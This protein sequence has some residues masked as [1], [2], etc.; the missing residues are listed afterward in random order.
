MKFALILVLW[1]S[2]LAAGSAYGAAKYVDPACANG[3][4]TYNAL[5]PAGTR[6]SGSGGNTTVYSSL[7]NAVGNLAA[8]DFLYIR[9]GTYPS[10]NLTNTFMPSG[11]GS[12]GSW[13]RLNPGAAFTNPITIQAYPGDV[14]NLQKDSDNSALNVTSSLNSDLSFVVFKDLI[15][16]G[17]LG[18]N[19]TIHHI[20]F[21]NITVNGNSASNCVGVNDP[22]TGFLWFTGGRYHGCGHYGFYIAA[23]DHIV[24]NLQIDNTGS[25]NDGLKLAI[26]NYESSCIVCP[27][28]NTYRNLTVIN[29]GAVL[30]WKGADNWLYNSIVRDNVDQG[31][32]AGVSVASGASGT[33]I[34]GNTLV[35]NTYGIILGEIGSLPT[36]TEFINNIVPVG[37]A[38]S[39]INN[40]TAIRLDNGATLAQNHNNLNTDPKFVDAPNGDY[41]PCIAA[42]DPHPTCTGASDAIDAGATLGSPFNVDRVGTPR[43]VGS[44]FD[45]GLY[46]AGNTSPVE[47]DPLI[48][49]K[50]SCDDVVT[51]LSGEGND[52]SIVGGTTYAAGKYNKGCSLDG[53]DDGITVADDDT[54][55][56]THGFTLAAWVQPSSAMTTFRPI[57]VKNASDSTTPYFLYASS[58][59]YCGN[60][61]V[62]AGYQ[63]ASTAV[64]ACYSTPLTSGVLTHVA[65]TYD[66]TSI[67]IYINGV[68]ATSIGGS[69]FIPASTGTLQI[70]TSQWGEW[71]PGV[72]DEVYVKNVA[73]T[74][75]DIVTLMNTPFNE[76]VIPSSTPTLMIS[77]SIRFGSGT[78]IKMAPVVE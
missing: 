39:A 34:Y 17:N 70:G 16:E 75:A 6:C 40:G 20:K 13:T 69:A 15:L 46:E 33:L 44:A 47:P 53:V 21:E 59:D 54:L 36:G 26:H 31:W 10:L 8:G 60:G 51:D 7:T 27:S 4:T 2:L 25:A 78:S 14:V 24:E 3:L 55:D 41:R 74:D 18:T 61:A 50:I 66:R 22:Q 73:L 12:A 67:K 5:A 28:R 23:S 43:P 62:I 42:G 58:S 37:T 57:I 65:A 19:G 63:T 45:I 64:V 56:L 30:I 35:G 48:V 71:F 9:T 1:L 68:L 77:G 52:G 32:P 11:T 72:L 76:V 29:A 38:I 49:V